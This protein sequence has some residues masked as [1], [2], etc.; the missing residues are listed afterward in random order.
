MWLRI[1]VGTSLHPAA[2]GGGRYTLHC[3][4]AVACCGLNR[5]PSVERS[6]VSAAAVRAALLRFALRINQPIRVSATSG[7]SSA[8]PA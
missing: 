5:Y 3:S 7:V 2:T 8:P 6:C 4:R 1:L